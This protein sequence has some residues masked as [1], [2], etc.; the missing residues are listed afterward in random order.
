M[1]QLVKD[2]NL[3][4]IR[5]VYIGEQGRANNAMEY[6]I[7][8]KYKGCY[9]AGGLKI[10]L[11]QKD[12]AGGTGQTFSPTSV[13]A[14]TYCPGFKSDELLLRMSSQRPRSKSTT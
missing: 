13:A 5:V 6:A 7:H 10:S 9:L 1:A 12:G 4:Q 2:G 11:A 14:M 3:P 8:H